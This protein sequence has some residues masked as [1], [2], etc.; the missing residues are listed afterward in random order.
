MLYTYEATGVSGQRQ[1][2]RFDDA[3]REIERTYDVEPYDGVDRTLTWS[4]TC[5]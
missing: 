4:Y 2:S 1:A 3:G 5:P